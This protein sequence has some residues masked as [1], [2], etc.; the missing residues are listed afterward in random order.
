MQPAPKQRLP[1]C[2][3][4]PL[5]LSLLLA[6]CGRPEAAAP[7]PR[8]VLVAHPL[9][10]AGAGVTAYSGDIRARQESPLSFRIGGNLVRRH[11]DA[12]DRVTRGAVLAELDPGDQRL[13]AQSAQAQLAAA[14]GE[15]RRARADQARFAQLA[16]DQL[17]S[18]SA[19]DAQ[20]A[21]LRAA[22]G[23]ARAARAARDVAR[24]QA[25]YT[26]LHAPHDGVI[27]TRE[28]EAGQ[29]V[30]AGQTVFTLAADGAREVAIALPEARIRS[31]RVGQPV[32]VELWNA[33]GAR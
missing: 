32:L 8:P 2:A 28:A 33:P 9:A 18:R 7:P 24:N 25:D 20:D 10:T 17:V 26:R 13:Q 1:A 15:L 29:V 6:A 12:G 16:K 22:D 11:A 27:A 5:A 19:L 14:E 23:Q 31:V 21:S 4:L 3:P 30:A